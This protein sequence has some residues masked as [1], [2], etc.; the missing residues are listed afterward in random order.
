[1][2]AMVVIAGGDEYK[3]NVPG[4]YNRKYQFELSLLDD[5]GWGKNL[6]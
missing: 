2:A 5:Y 1:M 6:H 4:T 3:L